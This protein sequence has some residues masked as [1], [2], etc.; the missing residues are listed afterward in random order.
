MRHA[1]PVSVLASLFVLAADYVMQPANVTGDGLSSSFAVR[2]VGILLSTGIGLWLLDRA[3]EW[4]RQRRRSA[5]LRLDFENVCDGPYLY[6]EQIWNGRDMVT[7]RVFRIGVT[8]TVDPAI[9]HTRLIVEQI[10]SRAYEQEVHRPQKRLRVSEDHKDSTSVLSS[11]SAVPVMWDFVEEWLLPDG[12]PNDWAFFCY[13]NEPQQSDCMVTFA[14]ME[15]TVRAEG[16]GVKP[17]R[18]R[19]IVQKRIPRA[20]TLA[21]EQEVQRTPLVVTRLP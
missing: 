21:G 13:A 4:C 20:D 15:V 18:I 5:A 16:D 12:S 10:K 17:R 2:M 3:I 6:E 9:E 14:R 7:H 11:K 19:F 1:L 8:S